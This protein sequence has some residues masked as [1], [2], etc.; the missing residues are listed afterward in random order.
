MGSSKALLFLLDRLL[1]KRK[2]QINL[3]EVE[4]KRCQLF[5]PQRR[6]LTSPGVS[7]RFVE[8]RFRSREKEFQQQAVEAWVSY[9]SMTLC[10][11]SKS[12]AGVN[13]LGTG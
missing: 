12:S 11:A 10:I 7:L 2:S 6:V 13:G 4:D 8:K 9:F 5:E 3:G 1:P